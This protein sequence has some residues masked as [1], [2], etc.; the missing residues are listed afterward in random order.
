MK[1]DQKD[2]KD[3]PI[4]PLAIK[5]MH[6]VNR[7]EVVQK[8]YSRDKQQL[9]KDFIVEMDAKKRGILFHY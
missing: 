9:I 4:S 2:K 6:A 3:F 5:A 1:A 8:L 7:P